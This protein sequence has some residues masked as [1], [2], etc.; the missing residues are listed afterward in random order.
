[1]IAYAGYLR[2]RAGVREPLDF[3]VKARWSLEDI[4]LR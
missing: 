4:R 1:M 3:T 2:Y